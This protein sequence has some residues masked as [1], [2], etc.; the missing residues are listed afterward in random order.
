MIYFSSLIKA[1]D[2]VREFN[3][4]QSAQHGTDRIAVD[5]PDGKGNRIAFHMDR[6]GEEWKVEAN[7]M[8]AWIHEAEAQLGA[9]IQQNRPQESKRRK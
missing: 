1:G 3:F 4:R 7:P 6:M 9:A 2:I 8:P 5:V